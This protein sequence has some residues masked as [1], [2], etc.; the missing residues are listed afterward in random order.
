MVVSYAQANKASPSKK[1][2]AGDKE[3]ASVAYRKLSVQSLATQKL[4]ENMQGSAAY[5]TD[6][7][8]DPRTE[9]TMRQRI[10][11]DIV[12]E[13]SGLKVIWGAKYYDD[14]RKVYLE[15]D[16]TYV[17]M[18][19]STSGSA[20]AVASGGPAQPVA[21][22]LMQAISKKAFQSIVQPALE[23]KSWGATC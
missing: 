11:A 21:P 19:S 20:S 7:V 18:A 8:V 1:K 2:N 16:D 10:E 14:L 15:K 9:Q 5:I 17:A 6:V 13:R 23:H 22:A 12:K 3:R 4:R